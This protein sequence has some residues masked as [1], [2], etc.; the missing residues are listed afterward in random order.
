MAAKNCEILSTFMIEITFYKLTSKIIQLV[1]SDFE[2]IL[3][4]CRAAERNRLV[5]F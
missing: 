5:F 3:Q 4:A 1:T 2:K